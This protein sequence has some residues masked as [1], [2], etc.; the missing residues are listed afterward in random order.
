MAAE[1]AFF[2]FEEQK[3]RVRVVEPDTELKHR[4]FVLSSPVTAAFNW[5][6]LVPELT[7]NDCLVV[8]MDMPGFGMSDCGADVSQDVARHAG[9]GW[10]IIDAVDSALGEGD[11]TWHIMTHGLACQTGL[12]MANM[13]PDSVSSQ[14]YIAPLMNTENG[15][16]TG[17][18]SHSRWYDAN[19][20]SPQGYRALAEK[21]FAHKVEDYVLDA[22]HKP[23]RRNGAKESFLDV[24]GRRTTP[25]PFMGFAPALVFWGEKDISADEKAREAFDKLV[26]EAETHVL[27]TAGHIPMETHSHALR[28]FLRGWIRYVG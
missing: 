2:T 14:I 18:S 6:K 11:S 25:E 20:A 12:A 23:F 19:I 28:D 22:M 7:Q 3:V 21:L 24:L 26:P 1:D 4:V 17:F 27:K 8:L 16:R 5:R 9:M 13:H 15:I 10:G